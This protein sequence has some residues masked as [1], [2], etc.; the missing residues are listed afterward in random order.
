MEISSS[1]GSAMASSLETLLP[2]CMR[3][4]TLGDGLVE[5]EVVGVQAVPLA[6]DFAIE[7]L[8]VVLELFLRGHDPDR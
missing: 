3:K 7:L 1:V 8:H 2:E 5:V 6:L 4:G